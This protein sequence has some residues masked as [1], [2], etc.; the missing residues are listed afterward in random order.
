MSSGYKG[1]P[2]SGLGAERA[3][4]SQKEKAENAMIDYFL[5]GFY[6]CCLN[7]PE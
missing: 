4:S 6:G 7:C 5:S 1:S 2:A 3:S